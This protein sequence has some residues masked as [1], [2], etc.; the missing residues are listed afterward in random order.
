[1]SRHNETSSSHDHPAAAAWARLRTDAPS[2][3]TTL[4]PPRHKAGQRGV[5]RLHDAAGPGRHVVAKQCAHQR[6]LF[7]RQIHEQILPALGLP[8]VGCHGCVPDG[9]TAS[10]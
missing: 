5:F 6:G 2:S 8:H 4:K 3:V 10:G 1:M 9:A 7:E